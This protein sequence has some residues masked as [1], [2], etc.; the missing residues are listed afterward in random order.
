MRCSQRNL[1]LAFGIFSL[2]M[3][4][5]YWIL[6][7]LL[8]KEIAHT[9]PLRRKTDKI[10]PDNHTLF[11]EEMWRSF[12]RLYIKSSII[13]SRGNNNSMFSGIA[14]ASEVYLTTCGNPGLA[15][16]ILMS[17]DHISLCHEI[18]GLPTVFWRNCY[19][20]CPNNASVNAWELYFEPINPKIEQQVEKVYCLGSY[21]APELVSQSKLNIR[22]NVTKEMGIKGLLP[23]SFHRRDVDGFDGIIT[24]KTKLY[25]NSLIKRYVRVLPNIQKVVNKFYSKHMQGYHLL[26]VHIRG[27]DH[28]DETVDGKLPPLLTWIKNA[29]YQLN[30]MPSPKK[31]FV[32]S[33][34]A[35]SISKFVSE[36]GEKVKLTVVVR[37]C[38]VRWP[39]LSPLV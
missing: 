12:K 7:E 25:A 37:G 15:S 23:L 29:K 20:V 4:L 6:G 18:G 1:V 36:F 32:A 33:D 9:I 34:N 24:R 8:F 28:G 39:G 27:T 16:L 31:I 19:T 11:G 21:A 30:S 5:F 14:C 22:R 3:L 38:W 10:D 35:E 17:L 26:A 2:V 13:S